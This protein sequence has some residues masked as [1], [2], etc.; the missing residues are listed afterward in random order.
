M[1]VPDNP[2]RGRPV[3]TRE[4]PTTGL[5]RGPPDEAPDDPPVATRE[6]PSTGLKPVTVHVDAWVL[7]R[8]AQNPD[9]VVHRRLDV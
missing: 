2:V 5:K 4:K 6:K 9:E 8:R 1:G 3:A 7:R